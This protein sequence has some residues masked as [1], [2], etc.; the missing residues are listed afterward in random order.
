MNK[1]TGP[2]QCAPGEQAQRQY[3]GGTGQTHAEGL[4]EKELAWTLKVLKSEETI[5]E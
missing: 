3:W 5:K 4:Y 1:A 2:D